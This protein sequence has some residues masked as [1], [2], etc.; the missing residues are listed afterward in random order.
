M[1]E[2]QVLSGVPFVFVNFRQA[3]TGMQLQASKY[4]R[5]KYIPENYF[6]YARSG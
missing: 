6:E 2:N 1:D 3:V 4:Q 5:L